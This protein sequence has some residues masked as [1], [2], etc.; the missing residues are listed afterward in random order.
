MKSIAMAPDNI[1]VLHAQCGDQFPPFCAQAIPFL[2]KGEAPVLAHGVP[3]A[4]GITGK[5]VDHASALRE[6]NTVTRGTLSLP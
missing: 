5:P 1:K 2:S 4:N 6:F 3:L